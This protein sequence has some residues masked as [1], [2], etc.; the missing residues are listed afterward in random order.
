[1]L[2]ETRDC[3]EI[4]YQLKCLAGYPRLFSF[5]ARCLFYQPEARQKRRRS[6]F[7][8]AKLHQACHAPSHT[9]QKKPP[10][11]FFLFLL[12]DCLCP[13][14]KG[15]RLPGFRGSN[16]GLGC[17]KA[18]CTARCASSEKAPPLNRAAARSA[19]AAAA[20]ATEAAGSAAWPVSSSS[21]LSSEAG[22]AT[23]GGHWW[24]LLLV[25]FPES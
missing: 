9:P 23:G 1:M 16:R 3:V 21:F 14:R 6:A 11:R 24:R 19:A 20:E 12:P 17:S 25:F 13:S 4:G 22:K 2:G 7:K 5:E 18:C 8:G 10:L 15:F